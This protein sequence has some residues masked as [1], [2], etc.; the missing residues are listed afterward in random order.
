MAYI[1][2]IDDDVDFQLYASM[3]LRKA[4]YRVGCASN[5]EAALEVLL[6]EAMTPELILL[7]LAMP[8]MDGWQ[9]REIQR[10]NP[11]LLHIP[12]IVMSDGPVNDE[13]RAALSAIGF[14][15]KPVIR[16]VLIKAVGRALLVRGQPA[17]ELGARFVELRDDH[18][19]VS[20]QASAEPRKAD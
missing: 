1:F 20:R 2:L 8:H 13:Y 17:A 7:D 19:V 9:F 18:L 6:G 16:T 4:G 11:K 14:L 5:G 10:R 12:V 15:V 3:A